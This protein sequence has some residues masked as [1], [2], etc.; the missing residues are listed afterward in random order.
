MESI[1]LPNSV[2]SGQHELPT[3]IKLVFISDTHESHDWDKQVPAGD[4]LIHTGDLTMIGRPS[5]L[6]AFSAKFLGLPHKHK[7]LIAGNHDLTLDR[8]LTTVKRQELNERFRSIKGLD[9]DALRTE[10]LGRM[11]QHGVV[12][13]EDEAAEVAGI[14]FYGSPYTPKHYFWGFQKGREMLGEVWAK[15]PAGVDV[16]LTHGPPSGIRDELDDKKRIG[17]EALL[18]EVL[19][20][21]KPKI[22]A[23]GHVHECHGWEERDGVHFVNGAV[24]DRSY[25]ATQQGIIVHFDRAKKEVVKVEDMVDA[26]L[27]S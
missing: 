12:Y 6:S 24:C 26:F 3:I 20:R 14:S 13:L 7:V 9:T 15:I 10:F 4:V 2:G 25:T 21:V 1:I 23:F 11:K 18:K 17:C 8:Y 19:Y 27:N 22:H 16:L 5:E